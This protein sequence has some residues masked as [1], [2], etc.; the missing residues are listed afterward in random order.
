MSNFRI[1]IVS[2]AKVLA[3]IGKLRIAAWRETPFFSGSLFLGDSW[4]DAHDDHAIHWA[5]YDEAGLVAAARLCVHR[6][7]EEIPDYAT[8][9]KDRGIRA[10]T[11]LPVASMNRLAVLPRARKSGLSM[12]LDLARIEK[13]NELSA[14]SILLKPVPVK[15]K[16]LQELGFR[17]ITDHVIDPTLYKEGPVV[18]DS[19]WMIYKFTQDPPRERLIDSK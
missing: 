11:D 2:D 3:E 17:I 7:L 15:V 6:R 13:A 16:A 12:L 9:P 1:Q 8:F 19:K 5:A 14:K 10:A 4:T 18:P